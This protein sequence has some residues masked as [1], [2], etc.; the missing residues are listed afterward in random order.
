[1]NLVVTLKAI[2][3]S[4]YYF[5]NSW[6]C[7]GWLVWWDRSVVIVSIIIVI[8]IISSLGR[9]MLSGVVRILI[10][11]PEISSSKWLWGWHHNPNIVISSSPIP[12]CVGRSS[13][14]VVILGECNL[15]LCCSFI[16]QLLDLFI[17]DLFPQNLG[18]CPLVRQYPQNLVAFCL[19]FW[20][21]STGL[22]F[23]SKAFTLC[24]FNSVRRFFN[25]C[26]KEAI[27]A[28]FC[29]SSFRKLVETW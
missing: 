24:S 19:P 25:S 4:Y 1:M 8:R 12:R 6:I 22:W 27:W 20:L 15:F 5:P 16:L 26:P 3:K 29:S 7:L 10:T 17:S 11:W 23:P 2:A 9:S 18:V 21:G 13:S 28:L 14:L